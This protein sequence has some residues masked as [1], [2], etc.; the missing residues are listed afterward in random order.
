MAV[1]RKRY[2][3]VRSLERPIRPGLFSSDWCNGAVAPHF[4][5]YCTYRWEEIGPPTA[6]R[7]IPMQIPVW[8]KPGLWGAV[9]GAIAMAAV[10]FSQLGW[11]TKGT[12]EQLAQERSD[13]AVVAALVPF[14]VIKAQQDPDLATLA[15]FQKEQSSYSRS[16]LVLKAGWATIG[17]KTSPD[18][19]LARACSEKLH[20]LKVG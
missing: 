14:C 1:E 15:K 20:S 13:T 9:A 5:N 11:T 10:G 16:D 3:G 2:R 18:N 6:Q 4:G 7:K 17:G 12:A 19:A 8:L